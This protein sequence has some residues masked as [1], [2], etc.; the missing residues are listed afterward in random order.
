MTSTTTYANNTTRWWHYHIQQLGLVANP[1]CLGEGRGRDH[2][3][4]SD[5]VNSLHPSLHRCWVHCEIP[6]GSS[7]NADISNLQ[8][9]QT[10]YKWKVLVEVG[11][12]YIH[13]P[14]L[15][16][17]FGRSVVRIINGVSD[18]DITSRCRT[19]RSDSWFTVRSSVSFY[20]CV[21]GTTHHYP[22]V[23]NYTLVFVSL[24]EKEQV[25]NYMA[26]VPRDQLI[27][28]LSYTV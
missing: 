25:F 20:D 2:V 22:Q 6:L 14:I 5:L 26:V 12:V 19:I 13:H 4:P 11:T 10:E 1:S 17:L 27:G 24:S 21:I 28:M 15:M 23:D 8:L 16:R 3:L 18:E 9:D 7:V